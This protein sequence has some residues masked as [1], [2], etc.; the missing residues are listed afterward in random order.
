M[1]KDPVDGSA[2][3]DAYRKKRD[4]GQTP[5]PFG[6][7]ASSP[8]ATREGA[9]VVH[10]HDAR[11]RHYDL[12]LEVGGALESF[13]VPKGPTL[14]PGERRLAVRTEP[15]PLE[16]LHFED[17]IPEGNYGAGP[18]IV[19]DAGSVRYLDE[20]AEEQLHKG[21]LEFELSGHKLHGRFLLI[22]LK[23][24]EK[25]WLLFKKH[26]AFAAPGRDIVQEK[27]RS[28]LSG[29]DIGEL[30]HASDI[31][32]ELEA[33][34][35]ALGAPVGSIETT[36]VPMRACP[37]PKGLL[38]SNYIFELKLD[39][40]R[41]IARKNGA[42]VLLQS[43]TL[44][45]VSRVYPEVARAVDK[46]P[47]AR[48]VLDGELIALDQA[49]Q[50]SFQRLAQRIHLANRDD[51]RRAETRIPVLY[52]VFDLLAIGDRDL[53]RLPLH[54]RK[55]LLQSLVRA[56]G[57]IRT[58]DR[59]EGDPTLLFDFCRERRME[60]LVAKRRDAP[61]RPG[62]SR[63][64]D[65]IKLKCER[66]D[67][68]V[69]V[70]YTL[71]E[72]GRA[73]LGALDVAA[74]E[75]GELRYRGKVGS[76][77]DANSIEA[78][79]ARLTP[80]R[81]DKPTTRGPY[82]AAPRGR[83]HV[84]PEL[85]V[86]VR[87]SGYTDDGNLRFPV[88]RGIRDDVAPE[89]CVASP[90]AD[91]EEAE[92][93]R[94]AAESTPTGGAADEPARVLVTNPNKV[95]FPADGITKQDIA[96]YYAAVAPVLLP[97]LRD[98]PVMLVRYPD[99]II[100]KFFYQWNVP[101]GLPAWV[102]TLRVRL[103]GREDLL[104]VFHIRDEATLLYVA[105][106]GAIPMHVIASRVPHLEEADFFNIDL[107]VSGGTF[108]HVITLARSLMDLLKQIGLTGFPKTSGQSGLH[109]L[110]PLGP[111]ISYETARALAD[112]LGHMLVRRHPDIATM[113]R[114]KQRRGP[115][116]YV[117]T[118]QTGAS[119]TIVA[120]YAV[121]AVPGARVSTPLTW[122]EVDDTLD[123]RAFDIRTVPRRVAR[124]FDPMAALLTETP[125][126]LAAIER[127]EKLALGR[128]VA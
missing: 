118:G 3:L 27:P 82:N 1:P 7:P 117:D 70:G 90:H 110:V 24:S 16:Y 39:G 2:K 14:N 77:L 66:D 53:R 17:V 33:R 18:M 104:E 19:W 29:L 97:H 56:P 68:F 36:M 5:E 8:G 45:D 124:I 75:A 11:R 65:W 44:R 112:L 108:T 9:Y 30:G 106:L 122:D 111:A 85:V 84:R 72:G 63:S 52:V 102:P 49:G 123:P 127:L 6:G 20:P 125:S 62:P 67:D 94:L 95:L 15:H 116:V 74:Y 46:L 38:G 37:A 79:L 73:R 28:V 99:G 113:E 69:V 92:I 60:G 35:A 119:R 120:P 105:S 61:Y 34:A 83:V 115:R 43:R 96:D 91:R 59:I 26:D 100:G 55:E 98:R 48:L 89:E 87:F 128:H 13:S 50:P 109:V 4:P 23:D 57:E 126:V 42:D 25:D 93:E 10:L 88:F 121:R 114:S 86:S 31:A 80:L 12:R 40:V 78:L 47:A 64:Y 21:K 54:A 51:I 103:P 22:R 58:L 81:T 41:C 32:S 76:G 107:D 71:G 101:A